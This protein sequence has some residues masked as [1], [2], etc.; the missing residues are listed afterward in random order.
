MLAIIY[1]CN[2][3]TYTLKIGMLEDGIKG[4][5]TIMELFEVFQFGLVLMGAWILLSLA[6]D[7]DD[8]SNGGPPRKRKLASIRVRTDR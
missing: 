1:L 2:I 8:P 6:H 5:Y 7:D 3:L 4:T